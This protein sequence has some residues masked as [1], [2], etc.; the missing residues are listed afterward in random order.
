MSLAFQ[1][2]A[3][4]LSSEGLAK[5]ASGL[6]VH[7]AEIWTVLAVE[8]S[9]CGYLS[10]RRPQILYE[11]HVFHRRTKG[12]YGDS[13]D[14]SHTK[15]GGYGSNGAS[16]HD[17]LARAVA[18]HRGAALCSASWGLGQIMGENFVPAGFQNVEGMVAA[19]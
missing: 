10:D 18:I 8:T 7:A 19:M 13:N 16:Q 17:R 6:G 14:I 11:R 9:G 1:G 4:A 5:V 12:K 3:P 15:P 2:T